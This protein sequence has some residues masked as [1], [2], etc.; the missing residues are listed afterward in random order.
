MIDAII[1]V[2][3][4]KRRGMTAVD[5]GLR[6]HGTVTIVRNNRPAYVVLTPDDYEEM[7]QA[8][9][10]ARVARALSDWREGRC[11]VTTVDKLMREAT[12]DE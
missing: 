1:P 8:A 7:A 12:S 10:E 4:I 2:Q 3:E 5:S 11:K 9:D 6:Q